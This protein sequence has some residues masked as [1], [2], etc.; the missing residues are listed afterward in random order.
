[1]HGTN[2]RSWHY[3][4]HNA[5]Y[6]LLH[7]LWTAP[8]MV[9][10]TLCARYQLFYVG[11]FDTIAW[12]YSTQ[13]YGGVLDISDVIIFVNDF[14]SNSETDRHDAT[15]ELLDGMLVIIN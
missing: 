15:K 4:M 11:L 5:S 7:Y 9:H 8:T 14:T 2:Y 1:M 6:G 13:L 3:F 10:D 12:I